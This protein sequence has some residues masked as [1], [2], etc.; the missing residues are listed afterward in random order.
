MDG[1]KYHFQAAHKFFSRTRVELTRI[2]TGKRGLISK[3]T[4]VLRR[5]GGGVVLHDKIILSDEL[6]MQMSFKADVSRVSP[7]SERMTKG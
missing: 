5:V 6:M 2:I 7:S 3:E 4:F 1:G